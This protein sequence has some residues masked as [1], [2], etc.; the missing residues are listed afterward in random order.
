MDVIYIYYLYIYIEY[1]SANKKY[2]I[3]LHRMQD[4]WKQDVE[5]R[6]PGDEARGEG[7][8]MAE[9]HKVFVTQN[10]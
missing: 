6:R 4:L 5:R 9:G 3:L 8:A 2:R 7:G 1:I 10:K